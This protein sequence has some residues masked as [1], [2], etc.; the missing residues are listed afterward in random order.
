MENAVTTKVDP[1]YG[2][3]GHA[4]QIRVLGNGGR[5]LD[6]VTSV[7]QAEVTLACI[8]AHR[9]TNTHRRRRLM[10]QDSEVHRTH[11]HI[12]SIS[13]ASAGERGLLTA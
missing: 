1:G 8:S 6:T 2:G 4:G 5:E 7:S 13:P 9:I 10:T 11:P 12:C 3:V